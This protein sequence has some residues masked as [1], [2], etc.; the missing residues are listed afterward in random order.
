MNP[1][2]IL[3]DKKIDG[4]HNLPII[5]TKTVQS[6]LNLSD[7]DALIFTSKNAIISTDQMNSSWKQIPS[8]A[9]ASATAKVIEKYNGNLVF[10]GFSGHG[11][12]FAKELIPHLK[13]KKALYLKGAK[14]VSNL[15]EILHEN[16]IDCDAITVYETSCKSY[17]KDQQP[18]KNAVIIFSSPSTIEC[19]FNSFSWD[20]SYSAV[21]IGHTTSQYLP[22]HIKA[23]IPHT[24][25][26]EACIALAKTLNPSI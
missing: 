19:F 9:I 14:T 13:N 26:L 1:I 2:Y 24:T 16:N 15:V 7:Y 6:D 4:V 5:Q 23:H 25:S 21:C 20:E 10:T 18:E 22:K 12:D 3:S 8:Y 11:N 17:E